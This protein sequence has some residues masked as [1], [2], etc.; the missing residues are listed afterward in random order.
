VYL[1]P[2]IVVRWMPV[3]ALL[4]QINDVMKPRGWPMSAGLCQS[5]AASFQT[6]APARSDRISYEETYCMKNRRLCM[7]LCHISASAFHC[8]MC[9]LFWS[10][11]TAHVIVI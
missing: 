2:S 6:H 8:N 9:G 3:Q 7:S 11:M 1:E 5:P 4:R 10:M